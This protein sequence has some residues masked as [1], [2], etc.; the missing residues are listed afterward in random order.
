MDYYDFLNKVNNGKL[1]MDYLVK[2]PQGN[3]IVLG[4]ALDGEALQ[5]SIVDMDY[6]LEMDSVTGVI[7]ECPTQD[8]D[9]K[10]LFIDHYEID[11]V[12]Y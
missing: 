10:Y 3:L 4:I 7:V 11:Q 1:Q 8:E 5:G 12:V 6:F 2:T 9:T